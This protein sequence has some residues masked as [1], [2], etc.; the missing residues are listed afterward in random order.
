VSGY[1]FLHDATTPLHA[2][3]IDTSCGV[4]TPFDDFKS[5][6]TTAFEAVRDA[7]NGESWESECPPLVKLQGDS[8]LLCHASYITDTLQALIRGIDTAVIN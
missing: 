4:L 3:F 7:R 8:T 5:I 1:F 2:P 6:A